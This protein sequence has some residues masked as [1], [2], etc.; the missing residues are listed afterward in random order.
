MIMSLLMI[1]C[2]AQ[3]SN[4]RKESIKIMNIVL[5]SYSNESICLFKETYYEH[6]EIKPEYLLNHYLFRVYDTTINRE[7]AAFELFYKEVY[8]I[9]TK[10][11]LKEMKTKNLA[12]SIKEWQRSNI[13]KSDIT[14][15][16]TDEKLNDYDGKM[17]LRISEPLFSSDMRK[18]VIM[19]SSSKNKTGGTALKI[20]V[21][22]NENWVIKGGIPI[23]TSG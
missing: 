6:P 19:I 11:E 17:F 15:L 9:V 23:G 20:F 10:E 3:E 18:A 7:S 16:S 12:W 2:K 13:K 21:K 8:G 1:C 5:N 14:L 4:D 22:E